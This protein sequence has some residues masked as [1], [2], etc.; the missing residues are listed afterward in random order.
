VVFKFLNYLSDEKVLKCSEN[1][2]EFAI[3]FKVSGNN[4]IIKKKGKHRI[5][6]HVDLGLYGSICI[7][8]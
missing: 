2:Y 1:L 3:T 4:M 7:F 8:F 6:I 5:L